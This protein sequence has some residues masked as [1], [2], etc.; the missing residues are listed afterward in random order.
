MGKAKWAQSEM[1]GTMVYATL[2]VKCVVILKVHN[3][4]CFTDEGIKPWRTQPVKLPWA[5]KWKN[6]DVKPGLGDLRGHAFNCDVMLPGS[7]K[8]GQMGWR[9]EFRTPEFQTGLHLFYL[10]SQCKC[11]FGI[12]E[13]GS[14]TTANQRCLDSS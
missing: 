9:Q 2:I 11:S 13:L 10:A 5:G 14:T 1:L 3:S 8:S 4:L 6:G 7:T 12:R